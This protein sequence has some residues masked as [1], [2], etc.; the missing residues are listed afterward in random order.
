[1]PFAVRI[2]SAIL[3]LVILALPA[4]AADQ[5]RRIEISKDSDYFGFDLRTVQNQTLDQCQKSCIDDQ[6]CK[7]FTYNAK[8]KWCFLK[9]DIGKLNSFVGSTAGKVVTA[10]AEPQIA[11]PEALDFAGGFEGEA[12]TFKANLVA[13]APKDGG[14]GLQSYIQ[15]ALDAVAKGDAR[16]A[17]QNFGTAVSLTPEDSALWTSLSRAAMGVTLTPD[18]TTFMQQAA[19]SAALNGY[20]TSRTTKDRAGA[21]VAFAEGL[22]KRGESRPALSAYKKSLELQADKTVDAAYKDLRARKGFRVVDHSVDTNAASPRICVQF[23]EYLDEADYASFL[24][25][26]GKAPQSVAKDDQQLCI[27]GLS[28]GQRYQVTVR[29]GLPATIGET[30]ES[31]VTLSIFVRDRDPF[32]RFNGDDFVL[33]SAARRSIPVVSVNATQTELTLYRVNDRSLPALLYGSQF[34]TQLD[35]YGAE[36]VRSEL[37]EAVWTGS[38]SLTMELNKETITAFPVDEA[39]PERKPGVYVMTAS[40]KG[41]KR[42]EWDPMATQWFVV[43]DIGVSTYTGTDG[44]T[45]FARS[46]KTARPLEGVTLKLL[47]K[48]N[49]LLG[50]ATTDAGGKAVF[51]PGRVRGSDGLAP[52]ILSADNKGADFVFLDMAKAGFD[53]SDRGVT[54][55]PAPGALDVYAY[56]ER[57]VYRPGELIHAAALARDSAANAVANLPL[58]FI[59]IRPDGVEERRIVSSGENGGGHAADLALPDNARQGAWQIRIHTDP[60]AD[61]VAELQ[62]LVEDFI[63]DRTEFDLS[64]EGFNDEGTADVA[65]DGRYLYGAPAGGLTLEGELVFTPTRGWDKFQGYA[66]GYE[67]SGEDQEGATKVELGDL[68]VLD[69]DGKASF[70]VDLEGEPDSGLMHS[71]KVVVRMREGGGRAVERSIDLAVPPA[72][73]MIGIRPLFEGGQVGE[74]SNAAF[75]IIAANPAGDRIALDGLKWSLVK[76]DR[77]YQWYREGS[78]WRYE[79]VDFTTKVADGTVNA[80]LDV[81]SEI[82]ANVSWGRYRLDVESTAED[83]PASSYEFNAGWYVESASTDTPDGLEIALDKASYAAGETARLKVSPRFAGELLITIGAEKLLAVQSESIPAEGK[84]VA[85]AI[86]AE[87]GAGAYITATLYRPG[88]NPDQMLPMRAIGVKWLA[89]DPADRKLAVDLGTADKMQPRQSLSIP[90]S[91]AGSGVSDSAWVMVSAVDVGILNLTNHQ[92]GD[93]DGWYFGQRQMGLEIRDIYGRLIDGSAGAFGTI[94]TG[95]DGPQA[96]SKGSAPTEKLIAFFSGPVKLDASGKAVVTF[97]IPQFNGTA[98]INAVAWTASGTG[99]ATKDIIIRDPIVLIASAPKFMAPDDVAVATVTI[100]NADGPAGEYDLALIADRGVELA[101]NDL[102]AK[103]TL[104]AGE[105]TSI[106]VPLVASYAGSG[107]LTARISNGSGLTVENAVDVPVRHGVLPVTVRRELPLAKGQS[108][109][110]DKELLADSLLGGASVNVSVLRS[111]AFDIPAM[112]MTL[113]RYPFGCAEQTTSRALPLLYANE[114]SQSSGM[115]ED[116]DL[117][118][119]IEDAI[120]RVLSYQSSTGSFGLWGPGSGDLWLDSYVTDFLTRARES[121]F[122]VPDNALSAA[123]ENLQNSLGYETDVAAK[124]NEIAYALYVLARNKQA[125]AT[126][127]RYYTESRMDEFHSPMA[128][129]HLGAALALYGDQPRAEA[130]FLSALNLAKNGTPK[131]LSRGDYGSALRDDAAMLAL[132]AETVPAPTALPAMIEH[133]SALRQKWTWTTTQEEAW[134]LMAA[135]AIKD[136]NAAI[137]LDVNGAAHTGPF[138][139]KMTGEEITSSPLIIRNEADS[140]AVA[141][142]TTVAAP[143]QPRDAGGNGFTISRAYYKLDGT[144]TNVTEARQNDRFVVVLSVTEQNNWPSRIVVTDLLPAGL[145]IDNPRLMGSAELSNFSWLGQTEVAHTEFRTDRFVAALDPAGSSAR[146]FN[147]AY[148]VRAVTPGTYMLPAAQVEDMYRPGFS[149]TTATGRMT[150]LEAGE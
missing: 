80:A 103:I 16:T 128:R 86:P 76:V 134:M 126:D 42:E 129:A 6:R 142:V 140:P 99:H 32:V 13:A 123:L 110:I 26:D 60:K 1:M 17:Y 131:D 108:I 81:E 114:L 70:T 65:V 4:Q 66:F 62:V 132:A 38:M 46:L 92:P 14:S 12:Q 28:Y 91:V 125:S 119:R 8:A 90:V 35:T 63:P 145:E 88:D 43:S 143:A 21:L 97:D 9:S 141:V 68:P 52:A 144:Q 133:V 150:V 79:A 30:I 54:G 149:A 112:L 2:L 31:P 104:A 94:R 23:S 55:R 24:L 130:A 64:S 5:S 118:A 78:S 33:P 116:P 59:F 41:E 25:L 87:W 39:L 34:L 49:E 15:A 36:R 47:A 72:G 95:G 29:Q 109:T 85:I 50:E 67:E 45:V 121:Q 113:D 101:A 137:G 7:A 83:G 71:A 148:T 19:T 122:A 93:P 69:E 58:T 100:A 117:K 40:T 115:P 105:R 98:R 138:A 44:L 53:L 73:D 74:N 89:I 147:L 102:P 146:T 18:E 48:N 77:N 11:A 127:L 136:G 75:K 56:T 57:G 22:E 27:D 20:L 10:N 61:P 82:A 139:Q 37:G 106:K 96:Q 135:R 111:T 124:G 107:S 3:T 120:G 51:D 84:E